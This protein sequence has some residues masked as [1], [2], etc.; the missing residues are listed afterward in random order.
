MTY[1]I[2]RQDLNA[3]GAPLPEETSAI[4]EDDFLFWMDDGAE[5]ESV[6]EFGADLL[7]LDD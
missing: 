4:F 3:V 2:E 1:H 7:S 6:E 5:P